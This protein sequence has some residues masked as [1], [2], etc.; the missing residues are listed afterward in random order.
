MIC[1]GEPHFNAAVELLG[2]LEDL[3]QQRALPGEL[4]IFSVA[5]PV[6]AG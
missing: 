2:T 6:F 5:A 1:A 4:W 3:V